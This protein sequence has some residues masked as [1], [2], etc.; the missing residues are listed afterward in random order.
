MGRNSEG[1]RGLENSRSMIDCSPIQIPKIDGKTVHSITHIATGSFMTCIAAKIGSDPEKDP[2]EQVVLFTGTSFLPHGSKPSS[3]KPRLTSERSLRLDIAT[4]E[5]AIQVN[6]LSS[7]IVTEP[8][9]TPNLTSVKPRQITKVQFQKKTWISSKM[10]VKNSGRRRIERRSDEICTMEKYT[11]T[12]KSKFNLLA[13]V[14]LIR[15]FL[16]RSG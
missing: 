13:S 7:T 1:Q 9:R 16:L 2:E 11:W 6:L 8:F 12:K 3:A 4:L 14:I 10:K 5:A 15:R